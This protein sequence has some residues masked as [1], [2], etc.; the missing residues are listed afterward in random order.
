M[1]K[2]ARF[3]I[4]YLFSGNPQLTRISV[5][6]IAAAFAVAP[7]V[8]ADDL[9]C[10][11]VTEATLKTA[12]TPRHMY[13]T[14][15]EEGKKA[16]N[17]MICTADALYIQ[18]EGNWRKV[19]SSPQAMVARTEANIRNA[20]KYRCDHEREDT[21]DG[22]AVSVYKIHSETGDSK[23]NT[24]LSISKSRGLILR[25][26]TDFEGEKRRVSERY[27]Y[28]EVKAPATK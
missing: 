27:D 11:E 3:A 9:G 6:V 16:E 25:Q 15:E 13:G 10:K 4:R 26:V 18:V 28:A 19:P 21:I 5:L 12:R 1:T 22:E 17:Q 8:R 23:T 20:R 24:E 7:G 2:L 14:T